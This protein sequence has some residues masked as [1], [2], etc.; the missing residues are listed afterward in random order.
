MDIISPL[1][2]QVVP[3]GDVTDPVFAQQLVGSGAAVK[4]QRTG[5]KLTAVAPVSGTIAKLH[6]HAYVIVTDEGVGVLVH[7]GI[8]TVQLKGEGFTLLAAEKS[9]VSVGDPIVTFEPEAIIAAGYDDICP[10]VVL[11][12]KPDTASIVAHN[13]SGGDVLLRWG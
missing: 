7:I 4:P 8:D 2:G 1:P 6:P 9:R 3:L 12:S 10:V 5:E 13:V 11:D